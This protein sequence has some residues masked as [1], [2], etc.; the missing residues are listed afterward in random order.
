VRF[1][2][3][4]FFAAGVILV[5]ASGCEPSSP[6]GDA[7]ISAEPDAGVGGVDAAMDISPETSAV[8]IEPVYS[9]VPCGPLDPTVTRVITA[10]EC[11]RLDVSSSEG[12]ERT[13]LPILRVSPHTIDKQS[14]PVIVL[15]G[16]PG[17]SGVAL[18]RALY[19]EYPFANLLAQRDVIAIGFRGTDE[20][21][22]GLDCPEVK[23]VEYSNKQVVQGLA[24]KAYSECRDRLAP[25]VRRLGGLGSR[26]D[27]ID[28]L[29]LVDKLGLKVWNVYAQSYGTRTALELLRMNPSGLRAVIL[30]SPVPD[31]V[32]L[33]A[34]ALVR[35]NDVMIQ[36]L[37]QCTRSGSCAAAF[38]G[39]SARLERVLDRFAA[40]PERRRTSD[41]TN[42]TI[43]ESQVW[44]V[45]QSLLYSRG[46]AQQ[47]PRVIAQFDGELSQIDEL[48]QAIVDSGETVSDAVYLSV[49]CREIPSAD[50]D[51]AQ[52]ANPLA[53]KLS[54]ASYLTSAFSKLCNLWGA[55]HES[56]PAHPTHSDV[57]VLVLT[58][59]LDPVVPP[60]W[61]VRVAEGLSS[62]QVL[63]IPGEGHVPGDSL[64]GTQAVGNF[65][66]AP[67]A[68]VALNCL[69]ESR[70]LRFVSP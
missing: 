51:A 10:V 11:G 41:G 40:Q 60:G 9:R 59:E 26:Q 43:D 21:L 30:D 53:K 38:P 24:D 61:G 48:L 6:V 63:T 68:P 16:G 18:L 5:S 50:V 20:A 54:E 31:G 37:D 45:L 55:A 69:R 17:Q 32:P 70:P 25:A 34:E 49:A 12:S 14:D 3:R 27:A 35:G 15:A 66:N 57:P 8:P 23:G 56:T 7:S 1:S 64:C 4:W 22:P 65:M 2:Q 28:V 39:I 46:G 19:L 47:V 36:V 29:A 42:V 13:T 62:A 44:Y 58:G 52:L 33:F 67:R